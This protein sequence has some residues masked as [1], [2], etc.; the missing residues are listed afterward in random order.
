MIGIPLT[1]EQSRMTIN[2]LLLVLKAPVTVP[3]PPPQ[4]PARQLILEFT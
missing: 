3:V 1:P 4:Q 2:E